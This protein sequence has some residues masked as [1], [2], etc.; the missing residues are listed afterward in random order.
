MITC[1]VPKDLNG[2]KTKVAFS[3][4]KRQLICFGIAGAVGIPFYFVSRNAL[5]TTVSCLIMIGIMMPFFFFG[6]YERDGFSAEK[7]LGHI[8]TQKFINP[9]IRPYRQEGMDL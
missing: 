5:G 7:I 1:K 9:G 3:L 6:L 2:I 4:T 8:I